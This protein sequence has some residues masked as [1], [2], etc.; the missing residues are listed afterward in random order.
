[1]G[2]IESGLDKGII[3]HIQQ[4]FD[5]V[6]KDKTRDYLIIGEVL[7]LQA[8]DEYPFNF[9]HMGILFVLDEDRD[10]RVTLEELINFAVFCM[11]H[12]KNYKTHE[13]QSQL[14]AFTTLQIWHE[15]KKPDGESDV[16]AWIARLLYENEEV[17][18][19]ENKPNIA[20]VKMDSVKHLYDFCNVKVLN[21]LDLQ[22][23]FDLLQQCGEE[24]GLMAL[25]CEE[26]DDYVPLPICQDFCLH[27]I[28]GLTKLMKEIGFF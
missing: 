23:F 22:R 24:A 25:E 9:S 13:F 2:N 7:Q 12:L 1:M 20:F 21:G 6:R 11:V 14:Q 3:E 28:K 15:L 5:R 16:V 27:Y 8:S 10:G 4:E 18:Y 26:L 17:S 19:F